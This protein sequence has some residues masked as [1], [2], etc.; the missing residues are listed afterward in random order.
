MAMAIVVREEGG[1]TGLTRRRY[2]ISNNWDSYGM[3]GDG[4]VLV[5]S[6]RT[7]ARV[8]GKVCVL[9]LHYRYLIGITSYI[10]SSIICPLNN[11]PTKR[12]GHCNMPN[13][14]AEN[15]SLLKWVTEQRRLYT[16]ILVSVLTG[17]RG[18]RS[19]W[20]LRLPFIVELTSLEKMFHI[21]TGG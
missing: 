12:F 15:P 20:R 17:F 3:F 1:K 21:T 9:P 7:I 13:D 14:L 19:R 10:M 8:Q 11:T 18:H 5:G 6:F 16:N 4:Y 2:A